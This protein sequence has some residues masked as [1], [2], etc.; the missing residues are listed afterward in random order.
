MCD[1]KEVAVGLSISLTGRFFLQGQEALQGI[2]L[3]QS[4]INA[5]GGIA[6]RDGEKRTVRLI[7]YDDYSQVSAARTNVLR[8]LREEKIDILFGPYQSD[9]VRSEDCGRVQEDSL[10]P[11]WFLR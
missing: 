3:W 8:L 1:R 6:V 2:R 5:Q 10:E 4:Y 9:H 7:W 11:W